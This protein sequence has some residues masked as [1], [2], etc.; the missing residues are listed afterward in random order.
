MARQVG[1]CPVTGRAGMNTNETQFSKSLG[2]HQSDAIRY[3][4]TSDDYELNENAIA[5]IR[6]ELPLTAL[7]DMKFNKRDPK[8]RLVP[9]RVSA[10]I[11]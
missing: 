7:L 9:Y 1:R 6:Q 2:R 10:L 5:R 4:L 3:L 11:R 8:G